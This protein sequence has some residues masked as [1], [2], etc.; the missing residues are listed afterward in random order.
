MCLVP[1]GIRCAFYV[2][3]LVLP[4]RCNCIHGADST[5]PFTVNAKDY[6]FVF[7]K[8][9]GEPCREHTSTFGSSMVV[10]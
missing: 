2:H 10:R 7:R 3:L 6:D 1:Y 9:G 5:I 4:C 8:E